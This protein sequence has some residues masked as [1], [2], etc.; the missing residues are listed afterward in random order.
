MNKSASSFAMKL[1]PLN[2][3]GANTP[4]SARRGQDRCIPRVICLATHTVLVALRRDVA[5]IPLHFLSAPD[6]RAQRRADE[7]HSQDRRLILHVED[8]IHLDE[9]HANQFT[10]LRNNFTG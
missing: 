7:F 2:S 4:G 3:R 9:L 8:R 6:A 5:R 1:P 10:R